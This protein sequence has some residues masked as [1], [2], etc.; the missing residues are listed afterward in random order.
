MLIK[1]KICL[2]IKIIQCALSY[3]G[4]F[5]IVTTTSA[6]TN[7]YDF[8]SSFNRSSTTIIKRKKIGSDNALRPSHYLSFDGNM[9][10][11][12]A[13]ARRNLMSLQSLSA[14][15]RKRISRVFLYCKCSIS[16][17]EPTKHMTL[18]TFTL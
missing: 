15:S 12:R 11:Y 6:T 8:Y 18:T 13:T 1:D 7:G 3:Q 9:W 10:H 2:R 4:I 17:L 16:S 5:V 14:M